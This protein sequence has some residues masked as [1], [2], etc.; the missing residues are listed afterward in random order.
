M[1]L[2]GNFMEKVLKPRYEENTVDRINFRY[3]SWL[4]MALSIL[5]FAPVRFAVHFIR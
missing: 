5:L 4:L 3:T 2:I 1:D